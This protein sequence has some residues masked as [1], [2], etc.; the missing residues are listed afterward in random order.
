MNPVLCEVC[1]TTGNAY[2]ARF[3]PL[4]TCFA[5]R[6]AALQP[7]SGPNTSVALAAG[8]VAEH[9]VVDQV[10]VEVIA[11]RRTHPRG[12]HQGAGVA[13]R[14]DVGGSEAVG[15][16]AGDG[17]LDRARLELEG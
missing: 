14:R 13:G 16:R 2:P 11:D 8:E 12:R 5:L 1:A 7:H 9:V 3:I 6:G 17:V 15:D 4:R 10:I